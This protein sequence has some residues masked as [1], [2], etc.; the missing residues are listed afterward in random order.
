MGRNAPAPARRC[1]RPE[2]G[3]KPTGGKTTPSTATS[4]TAMVAHMEE[5]NVVACEQMQRTVT[6]EARP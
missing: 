4:D 5:L 1:E 6:D 2:P 3:G